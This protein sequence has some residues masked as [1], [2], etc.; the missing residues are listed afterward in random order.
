MGMETWRGDG[1]QWAVGRLRGL[2][3]GTPAMEITAAVGTLFGTLQL[4]K[5]CPRSLLVVVCCSRNHHDHH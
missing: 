5:A 2:A 4:D 1:G 3:M